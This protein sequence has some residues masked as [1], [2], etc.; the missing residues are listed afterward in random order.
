MSGKCPAAGSWHDLVFRLDAAAPAGDAESHA[1]HAAKAGAALVG[2]MAGAGWGQPTPIQ[3]QAVP[4]LMERRELLAV[5]PTGKC[6][7]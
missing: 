2:Q 3:R 7:F 4:V 6:G 1:A 5:A